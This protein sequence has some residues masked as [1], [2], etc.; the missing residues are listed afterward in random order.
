MSFWEIENK[1]LA[2]WTPFAL[3]LQHDLSM[4]LFYEFLAN[5]SNEG[6]LL[7]F[8]LKLQINVS[9]RLLQK[10]LIDRSNGF[11]TIKHFFEQSLKVITFYH[12]HVF[13]IPLRP[14]LLT[15]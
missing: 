5:N 11:N 14:F 7:L 12:G 6:V 4:C 1:K 10:F 3:I 8:K 2:T 15:Y 13:K 9:M